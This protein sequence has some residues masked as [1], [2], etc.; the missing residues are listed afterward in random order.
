MNHQT[1]CQSHLRD[2]RESSPGSVSSVCSVVSNYGCGSNGG[3]GGSINSTMSSKD[4]L[5]Q[6]FEACKS[7]DAAKVE[8]LATRSNVSARDTSGR[9]STAL[10]FA[11]GEKM[12]KIFIS[13]GLF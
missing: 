12:T 3:V 9:K 2:L 11:S 13:F 7:G 1:T 4:Q 8:Q 5:K 10:H 6:L